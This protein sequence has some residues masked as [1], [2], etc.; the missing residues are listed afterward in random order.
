MWVCELTHGLRLNKKQQH[1]H[2]CF[3]KDFIKGYR[4][5]VTLLVSSPFF[6]SMVYVK[7]VLVSFA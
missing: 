2:C 7:L 1:F 3:I 5:R 6:S 4:L